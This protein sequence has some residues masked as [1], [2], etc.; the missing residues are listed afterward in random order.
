[1]PNF[2]AFSVKAGQHEHAA[3][4]D[5]VLHDYTLLTGT[6]VCACVFLCCVLCVRVQCL[7]AS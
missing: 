3:H 5:A 7:V 4:P 6:A 2:V 1:M